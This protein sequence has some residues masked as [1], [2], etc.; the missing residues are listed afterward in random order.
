MLPQRNSVIKILIADDHPVVR[1]GLVQLLANE[2]DMTVVGAAENGLEALD[3]MGKLEW[4]VA[5]LDY[6]MPGRSGL[7][8]IKEIKRQHPEHPVLILSILPEDVH[9]A[10]VYKAGGAGYLQKESATEE[11][12]AAIRKVAKGGKY[13]SPAF[14]EKLASGLAHNFDKPL[15]ESLSDREYR[16]MWLLASGKHI[17]EIA[18][19]LFLSPSTISTYRA[20]I[21]KKLMVTDNAALVRY[22][23]EQQL[24]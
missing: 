1:H 12:T 21:L 16:V 5:V 9:A 18:A 10:Q 11:L 19:E 23:I 4:D 17:N 7:D 20:R 6:S 2:P 8:L 15:H 22:A 24:I 14:A 3:L 13:V